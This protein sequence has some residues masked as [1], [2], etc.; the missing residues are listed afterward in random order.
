M[1]KTS[2]KI[3]ISNWK[4]NPVTLK[5]AEKLFLSVAKSVS[6]FKKTDIVI[7]PPF[8]YLERIKSISW[9][10][11]NVS[12]GAQDAYPGD[13]GAYTGEVSADMLYNLGARYVILGHSERRSMGEN[14]DHVNKKIKGALSS[15]LVPVLCVGE[16]SRDED[17]SYF[18]AV[19]QQLE[20]CLSGVPKG[21]ISKV[22][23]AYEPVWAISTTPGRKDATPFDCREMVIFIKKVLTDKFG[24]KVEMPR[25][26]YG[27]SVNEKDAEG[28][29]RDGA[30]DGLL[31][32]RASLYPSK[33]VQIVQIAEELK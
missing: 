9:R 31:P 26:I 16:T 10:A 23:I 1:K 5:E 4:M 3:I 25:I 19:K 13:V 11:K 27:G 8:V 17:H 7:C 28:F 18:A 29:L 24:A 15:G 33:F 30:V 20:E 21:A 32:G 22:I 6:R 12:L 14:N 2:K